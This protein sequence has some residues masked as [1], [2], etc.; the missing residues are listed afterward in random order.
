MT[1][2]TSVEQSIK[3]ALN[4]NSLKGNEDVRKPIFAGF[5]RVRHPQQAVR[6]FLANFG[7]ALQHLVGCASAHAIA[8]HDITLQHSVDIKSATFGNTLRD[9]ESLLEKVRCI[10]SWLVLEIGFIPKI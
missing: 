7:L 8:A 10:A 2:R 5:R 3:L 6:S 1:V 4:V 9:Y